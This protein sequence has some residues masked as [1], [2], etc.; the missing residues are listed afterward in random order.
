LKGIYGLK[1]SAR[2]WNYKLSTTLAKLNLQQSKV[3]PCVFYRIGKNERLIV[4]VYVDDIIIA[5][6]NLQVADSVANH[7]KKNFDTTEVSRGPNYYIIGN[8]ISRNRQIK[9]TYVS[10]RK[11]IMDKLKEF[12]MD[13]SKGLPTPIA[14]NIDIT[15]DMAPKTQQEVE[16]MKDVPYRSAVGS[17]MH[18]AT[19]TRF[20]ISAAVG[21]VARYFSNPGQDHWIA[22]KRIFR[23]LKET[24][25]YAIV[26]DGRMIGLGGSEPIGYVDASHASCIDDRR[27][28][29]GYIFLYGGSAICWNSKKQPTVALSTSEAEYMAAAAAAQQAIWI[30]NLLEEL[31]IVFKQPC[32]LREDNQTCILMAKNPEHVT[33]MKHIDIRHHFLREKIESGE[34]K[35]E[36]EPTGSMIADMLT[37][38]L[39]R[40]QFIK[41]RTTAGLIPSQQLGRSVENISEPDNL[42][43]RDWLRKNNQSPETGIKAEKP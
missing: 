6:S 43:N 21:A 22:V 29:T 39:P 30:K 33:R 13:G 35:I 40:D 5:A 12:K 31:G 42:Q 34:I 19:N 37:K 26:Y 3:D 23:Y 4:V 36:Y 9:R 17:L 14:T 7:L 38:G 16:D 24:A 11:Y 41:L 32:T 15:K 20:D 8:E 1:Q 10:Q 18:T 28:V 25:D 2:L 27:S